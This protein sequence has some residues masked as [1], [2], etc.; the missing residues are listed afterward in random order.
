LKENDPRSAMQVDHAETANI[1]KLVARIGAGLD[2]FLKFEHADCL[3]D[4][5]KWRGQ[6]DVPLPSQGVGIDQVI[7]D[8]VTH[9]IPFGS[10]VPKPGFTSFITTGATSAAALAATAA[11]IASPQRYGLTA[12]NLL[13]DVSLRW[14]ASMCQIGHMQGV[15]SSGG[16]VA[17]LLALGAARQFAFEKLGHDA[18][19]NGVP[20][21]VHVYASAESHH[22]IQ[23]SAGVLGLGRRAI[24][25]IACDGQGRMRVDA[26]RA[27]IEQDRNSGVV[28][29]A[30]VASA[31]TT[32]TGAIDP[33]K[34]IGEIAR[35]N[36]IWFHVDGAYGLPGI[37]D[38]RI[39]HLYEGLAMADSVIV[40]PHKWL[41]AAVGVAA[42]FV[43]DRQLLYRAFTQE[44]ADYLEGAVKQD[45]DMAPTMAH[46]LDDF[47]VPYYDYGVELSA[48]CRGVVVW[49]LIREIGVDGMTQRIKRHND[50][51]TY[52]ATAAKAH[53]HLELLLEPTLSICCFRYVAPSIVDLD[54]FN[55]QLHRR[56]IRENQNLPSTTVVNGK[57]ALRPCFVGARTN[58]AHA[59]SLL[60]DVLRIGQ[61]LARE[62]KSDSI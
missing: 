36:G 9:V 28:P 49:A 57:L 23:R 30:I 56:L 53:R 5:A 2:Q 15:Y 58:K 8:L 44:P 43:R 50:M 21:P 41:G 45:A 20:Q 33:L 48:P 40:D 38:E 11:S 25:T 27:A 60:Q 62:L 55:R 13:E 51:A 29:M 26:L 18:G 10:V 54:A 37:L 17:N 16:S 12:F 61:D 24:Q 4:E 31:G 1:E 3:Q 7:N 52:L 35:M 6:L 34:E 39:R 22:T 47:G 14:L 19:A 42:T 59:E 46:S 32:N